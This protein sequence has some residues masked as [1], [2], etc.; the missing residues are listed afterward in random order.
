MQC[1]LN[2]D[3]ACNGL[4]GGRIGCLD[5]N[6]SAELYSPRHDRDIA[7]QMKEMGES[8]LGY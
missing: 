1:V 6:V 3:I 7:L 5:H 8:I 2:G 4:A